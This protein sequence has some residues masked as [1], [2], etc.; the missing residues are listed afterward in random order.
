MLEVRSQI[1]Y[2]RFSG[3]FWCGLPQSTCVRWENNGNGRW[4]QTGLECQYRGTLISM[5]ASM[6]FGP[7]QEA[8]KP[9][10][11]RWLAGFGVDYRDEK[12]VVA[13]LGQKVNG[14]AAE[15]NQMAVSFCFLRRLY[16]E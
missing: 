13:F 10:W 6:I 14:V 11:T 16:Q 8:I 5:V 4:Q 3:C 12:G 15:R 1:K 7:K 9:T 2:Q